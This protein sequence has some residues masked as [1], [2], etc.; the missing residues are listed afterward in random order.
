MEEP[1]DT[2]QGV[3]STT[4][5]Y[6]GGHKTNPT[7]AEVSAGAT[8]HAEAVEITYDPKQ[9]S[10]QEL[11]EIFWHNIDPTTRD[12]QFCDRGDQY[13][14][15]IFYHDAEQQRAAE[16][17]K[18]HLED[19]GKIGQPIVTQIVAAST[20]YP[21]E[22]YHQDY[23][24]KNPLRYRYYRYRCGRDRRLKEIWPSGAPAGHNN[25]RDRMGLTGSI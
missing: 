16:A 19:G 21:A 2:R 12:R 7:Y 4:A 22:D 13:R 20:F 5:G 10:Y 14:T 6:T 9:I 11:L 15:A 25:R 1:F 24:R 8:G 3:I 23:Y 17:S 18:K